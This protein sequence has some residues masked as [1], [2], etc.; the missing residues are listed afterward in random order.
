[1]VEIYFTSL[2][3]HPVSIRCTITMAPLCDDPLLQQYHPTDKLV[4]V[5]QQLISLDALNVQ[6][7]SLQLE[8][9][10]FPSVDS[11]TERARSHCCAVPLT[12]APAP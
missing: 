2:E 10:R 1:M 5:L 12:T 6:L 11:L 9:T 3:L 7:K 4:G 8:D